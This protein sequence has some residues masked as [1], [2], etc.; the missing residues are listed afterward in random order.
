MEATEIISKTKIRKLNGVIREYSKHL[1][2]PDPSGWFSSQQH[3]IRI[4]NNRPEIQAAVRPLGGKLTGEQMTLFVRYLVDHPIGNFRLDPNILEQR[5]QQPNPKIERRHLSRSKRKEVDKRLAFYDSWEWKKARYQVLQR[6]GATCM[7]CGAGRGDV[8][9]DGKPVK[10]DVDHIKPLSKHWE[11][12]L[13]PLNLQVLCHDC[14]KGKGAWD[15]TDYRPP[16]C[17]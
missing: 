11:L 5:P 16:K 8:S 15:T 17:S 6:Y 1:G 2:L 12:R 13:D 7:L 3:I 10:I 14:N 9:L 4:C